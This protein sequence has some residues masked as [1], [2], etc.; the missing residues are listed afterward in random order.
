MIELFEQEKVIPLR[1]QLLL[2]N[3][4]SLGDSHPSVVVVKQRLANLETELARQKV[5]LK[6]NEE[7]F[8]SNK[9]DIPTLEGRLNIACGSSEE[10]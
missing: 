3:E 2:L 10:L 4:Q 8:G 1:S 9:V 5:R 7:E 6:V